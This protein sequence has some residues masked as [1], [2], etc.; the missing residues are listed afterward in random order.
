M[1]E[2]GSHVFFSHSLHARKINSALCGSPALRGRRFCFFHKRWRAQRSRL[3]AQP[4]PNAQILL[5]LPV[6]EDA[7]SIQI[8]LTQVMRLILTRQIDS[9]SAGL[10]LYA[11]QTASINLKQ[12]S[13]DPMATKVILDPRDARD[14][15]VDQDPW[16]EEDFEDD[17]EDNEDEDDS[18]GARNEENEED[19][20]GQEP[21]EPEYGQVDEGEDE[22][23]DR[24][25]EYQSQR[26]NAAAGHNDGAAE[27]NEDAPSAHDMT[28]ETTE[29]LTA[30]PDSTERSRIGHPARSRGAGRTE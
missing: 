15:P 29:E 28:Q 23:D 22:D 13:F 30:E 14:T 7:N 3:N 9:K 21:G 16:S 5:R 19:E 20:V 17:D 11:L 8:V 1:G 12:T 18:E 2:G 6:L 25:D 4:Q 27:G 24:D 10:L 26:L